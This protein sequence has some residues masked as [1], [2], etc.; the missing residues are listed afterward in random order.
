MNKTPENTNHSDLQL[1][2]EIVDSNKE[3][4]KALYEKYVRQVFSFVYK[5]TRDSKL[6]E[7]VV[8]DTM[9]EVWKG[10]ANFK[11]NSTVLTWI[12]GIAH[13][14]SMNELRKKRPEALDPEEFS[15]FAS[16]DETAEEIVVKKDRSE[17][18]NYAMSELSP[19]HRTVLE[20]TFYN[21][22]SY[23]E[24]AEIMECPVNTVKTRMFYAKNK[25]KESLSK[26]GINQQ[27]L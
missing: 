27:E 17:R 6:T 23:Q 14:K 1:I 7:E 24:I 19:E 12:F 13:N 20:L 25:L 2:E 16:S 4:F 26:Y 21:G 11:G 10:A 3:A 18:M 9:F 15:R 5:I 22:L 8:N